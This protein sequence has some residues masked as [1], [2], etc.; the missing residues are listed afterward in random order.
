VEQARLWHVIPNRATDSTLILPY[1][2]ILRAE[3]SSLV[4]FRFVKID[5]KAKNLMHFNFRSGMSVLMGRRA[6]VFSLSV[7]LL[8]AATGFV[9]AT[10]GLPAAWAQAGQTQD[11]NSTGD[12]DTYSNYSEQA[13]KLYGEGQFSQAIEMYEKALAVAPDP[14]LPAVYNNLAVVYMRRGNYYDKQKQYQNSLNDY[15]K[16]YFYM[17]SAWP[18]G[19]ERTSRHEQNLQISQQDLNIGYQN[20]GINPSD[21]AKHLE[22][23]KQLRM[24]GKFPEA[25]VEYNQALNLDKKDGAAAKALGDLFNVVNLPEKS[26]KYYAMAVGQAGSGAAASSNGGIAEDEVLVQ[27]GNAQYKTGEVDK[28]VANFDKALAINPGNVSALN[29]L[30]KIRLNEIKF[31]PTSVLGHANLGS[32]YQKK[33][34]YDLA[35]QQYN[36][37]EFFAERDRQTSFD[38]KKLIRLNLGLL[39]QEQKRYELAVKAYDTV[40]QVDPN[41]LLAN[42]YKATLLQDSGNTDGALQGYNRV[43]AI[44]PTYKPAQ[45]KMLSLVKQQ[46]D[47]AKVASGLIQYGDRF[48]SNATVQEQIG[49]EFHQ[50]KDLNNAAMFYQR[51]LKLNPQMAS[52]WANLGAVYQSQ[53]KDE[54]S[55]QAFQKAQALDPKNATFQQLAKSSASSIGYKAYQQAVQLQQ[56][57]KSQEA[58]GYFQKALA[59]TDTP[60]IH[61][62]YG[63]SLQSAGQLDAAIGEYQ[64]ALA[65]DASNADYNYYL[66]TAYHQKKDLT[67]AAAAYKKTLALK[68]DYKDAQQALASIDQQNASADLDKAIDAYNKKNYPSAL[69]LVN[70]ALSKHSKD[71]MAYYYRGLV[72]DAQKKTTLAA[73]SYQEAIRLNPDFTDAY[74]AL[75][76]ALDA[77]KDQ[78]GAKGAFEKFLS[79]SGSNDD[80]F[81]KYARERVKAIPAQ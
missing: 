56:Q 66:G 15:R 27:L 62:A 75:G 5:P 36:A 24:Q 74:Y 78:R 81:V 33:K 53:G 71:S 39:F 38:S 19:L 73:Q 30:E 2:R 9:M 42:Y 70:Q 45:D 61:A 54:E 52:A 79:L 22:M 76:V 41:N 28:A 18:E 29:M 46:S 72:L 35:F 4:V 58:I 80:D 37:A 8:L 40:L 69:T 1:N 47:P 43:L 3:K 59:T 67:K 14:S 25:I 32:V 31:N 57:G 63:V 64:K 20:L 34:Q 68:P 49:E 23:A 17:A 60:D 65:Q 48:A 51:A 6:A 26:K 44:D 7:S 77:T 10:Q 13:A 12:L 21:K 50:R 55:A 16:A 11:Y